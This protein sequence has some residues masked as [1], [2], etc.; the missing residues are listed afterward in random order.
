MN[1]RF[2]QSRHFLAQA[3][4][5][6]A[7]RAMLAGDASFR[8]YERLN[9]GADSAVLMDAA[10]PQED[11][12]PFLRIADWLAAEGFCPP[13]ILARD[14]EHGFLLLEDLGDDLYAR[15]LKER[16]ADE[17]A[18]YEAAIDLLLALHERQAPAD[19]APYDAARLIAEAELFLDWYMPARY[20]QTV[21]EAA[22]AEFRAL[23]TELAPKVDDP[24]GRVIVL[25]D[26]HA[27]NLLWLPARDGVRRVGLL[28]FQDA[29]AGHPAYDLVSLL[30]DAR[31]DV[32]PALAEAMLARYIRGAQANEA[33]FRAAYAILGAQ[34][35]IRI[36][37]VFTRLWKRD[38]K[39]GYQ[40]FMPRMWRLV[41]HDLAHP[42]LADLKSWMDRAV[43]PDLRRQP[44]PG[45][46]A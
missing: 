6:D 10:P 20:G 13:A 45:L 46:A 41:E 36:L 38:G 33:G 32:N 29:V 15:L 34:R 3:G 18:L 30:E 22:R 31:R 39:P 1:E 7:A 16:R 19:L 12:R 4:W 37:G 25:R 14:T 43:P 2:E 17:T 9:R 24:G 27:E 8:K 5:G 23:W 28:D 42:A 35:N 11:V 26:F 21:E 40:A 44:L